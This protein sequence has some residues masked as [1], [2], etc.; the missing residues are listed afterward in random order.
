LRTIEEFVDT[1]PGTLIVVSHDRAFL[2]RTVEEVVMV[3]S[4]EARFVAGG[5]A[6]WRAE[7]DAR[8]SNK[9]TSVPVAKVERAESNEPGASPEAK[10]KSKSTLGYSIR[11]AEKEMAKLERRR[12]S[13]ES[14][15]AAAG[16]NHVALTK[17]GAQLAEVVDQLTE[18][19]ERWLGLSAE[20]EAT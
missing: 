17:I 20:L 5:Y 12:A 19:E 18:V 4:G 6:G 3:E 10:R 15:L 1:W 9:Q 7:R 8:I 13:F 14:E 16:S 11:E 2:D